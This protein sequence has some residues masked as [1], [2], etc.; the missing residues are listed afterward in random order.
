MRR[1]VVADDPRARLERLPPDVRKAIGAAR[2]VIGMTRDE[3]AMALGFPSPTDTPDPAAATWRDRTAHPDEPVD[4]RFDAD[5]RHAEVA[6]TP[7]AVR[8]IAF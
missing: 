5:G 2:V 6:G 4:R 1:L 3:V 8:Q 7:A